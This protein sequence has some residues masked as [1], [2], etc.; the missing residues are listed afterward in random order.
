MKALI[1]VDLQYDFL[2]GGALAVDEGDLVIPIANR[3]MSRFD[4][5]V[6]TK[7]FHPVDHLSFAS[8][9]PGRKIGEVIDL[10]GLRQ[11]LWPDHCV[12]RTRGAELVNDLNRAGIHQVFEK[13]K[14]R[15]IDSYSAFFDNGHR[16]ET[17]LA[18]YLRDKGVSSVYI[19]GL[20]TDYCVKFT[21]VDAVAL[22]FPTHVVLD[23]C[24]GVDLNPGDIDRAVEKMRATGVHIVDSHNTVNEPIC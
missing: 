18:V 24:R 12:E 21:A 6:A 15:N 16:Q 2:P 11:T 17:G 19:M 23:G 1:L 20:A 7:D 13:G 10:D 3:L 8:Q 22:G 5:V 14:A 4:L 9:H